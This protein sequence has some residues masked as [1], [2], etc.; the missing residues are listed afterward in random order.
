MAIRKIARMGHPVLLRV[1]EPV[2]DPGS[3]DVAALLRDM[4]DT[5]EDI[6][7][8]GIAAP[9]VY[10]P[11]RIVIFHAPLDDSAS[12]GSR[13]E[14]RQTELTRIVNPEWEAAGEAQVERW[15]S[16]LSVPGMRGLVRRPEKIRYRGLT[17][18]GET[19]DRV[20][21]GYHARV[22]QHE[23]D[24]LDGFLYPMRMEDMRTFMFE[25]EF[26]HHQS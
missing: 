21:D 8:L 1:S 11:L 6:K 25:T 22:V 15:E 20:V 7:G 14:L 13:E 19:I 10:E 16:C 24:H 9:Q 23:I 5:L 18:E 26:E 4:E 2:T 17:P 12:F 3:P